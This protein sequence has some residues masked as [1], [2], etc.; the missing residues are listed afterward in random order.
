[1]VDASAIAVLVLGAG[2]G[3]RYTDG[4]KL[5]AM[6]GGK[7]VA[8]HILQ[9]LDE[10]SWGKRI[11]TCRSLAPWTQAYAE[12]GFTLALTED[13]ET[14]MLGSLHRGLREISQE[15]VLIC[16]A[17]MPLVPRSHIERL[18]QLAAHSTVPVIASASG[19]YRG[20]PALCRTGYLRALPFAG[21]G[22]AR[23]L[24]PQADFV[25]QSAPVFADIDTVNDFETIRQLF[26]AFSD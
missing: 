12:A 5:N 15:R 17:D 11:V 14:G 10:F 24:L 8:H 3:S 16:L 1:M 20:P 6:L 7:P 4:D 25:E 13:V 19:D 26:N 21:E 23:S 18:L 22:G 9:V 2:E